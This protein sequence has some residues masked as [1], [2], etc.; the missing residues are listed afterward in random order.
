[1]VQVVGQGK[2]AVR[3]L[4]GERGV[5]EPRH[6][7]GVSAVRIPLQGERHQLGRVDR[8]DHRPGVRGGHGSG[9]QDPID[10]RLVGPSGS[11]QVGVREVGRGRADTRRFQGLALAQGPG[12]KQIGGHGAEHVVG[13]VG[14]RHR[15]PPGQPV[16]RPQAHQQRFRAEH[17][18]GRSFRSGNHPAGHGH[19]DTTGNQ[20]IGQ[21][22][23]PHPLQVHRH[24][25]CLVREQADQVGRQHRGDR[26]GDT[27]AH[28]TGLPPSDPADRR[29]GRGD[30]LQDDLRPGQQFGTGAGQRD[31][32][33]GAGEQRRAQFAL[34]P[35]DQLA[36]RG[37]GQVQSLGGPAE[38]QLGGDRDKRFQLAQFHSQTLPSEV[39][40]SPGKRSRTAQLFGHTE[41]CLSELLLGLPGHAVRAWRGHRDLRKDPC[42][43]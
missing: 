21:P 35:P 10:A 14:Q 36:E 38:V 30:L 24:L 28:R 40:K 1:M 34:Q 12:R 5:D 17:L 11:G 19:V 31:P 18:V 42:W 2:P 22:G 37:R 33:G 20:C 9:E 13:Q 7:H 15:G 26:R 41:Q 23:Q 29:A 8:E 32:S 6:R 3:E 16:L 27:H 43:T 39:R 25:R 4:R